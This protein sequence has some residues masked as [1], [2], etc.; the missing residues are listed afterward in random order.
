M[1]KGL[2]MKFKWLGILGILFVVS[3]CASFGEKMSSSHSADQ[4]AQLFFTDLQ[5]SKRHDAYDLF[6]KGL[7]NTISFAQFDE[8]L[9]TL[10]DHWGRLEDNQTAVMP[11]H[12]RLGESDFIP[13]NTSEESIKRYVYDLKFENAQVNCDLTLVPVGG[14]YKIVWLSFWGSS[15]YMTPE[16]NS[17]MQEIFSKPDNPNEPTP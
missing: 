17:K 5:R 15:I 3:G 13:L 12:K 11:F 2:F 10:Q 14:E 8:L 6:A 16:I 7:S 1:T 4:T 9:D